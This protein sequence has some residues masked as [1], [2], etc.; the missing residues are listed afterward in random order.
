MR[1]SKLLLSAGAALV[2]ALIVFLVLSRRPVPLPAVPSSTAATSP[3]P[4]A[5]TSP[6]PPGASGT[7]PAPANAPA[8]EGESTLA[9]DLNAPG[10]TIQR[11]LAIL[12][13]VFTAWL[14]NFPRLGNPGGENRDITAAL[15]GENPV[16]F[17]FISRTHRA[18][19]AAGELCDRWG[20]PFRFHQLS[21]QHMELRSAGPDRRFGTPDDAVLTPEGAPVL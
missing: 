12:Q 18:I 3:R 15:C 4:V 6:P 2:L 5:P 9:A 19:N 11:D 13:E 7:A 10:G 20:T 8:V 1:R 16:R 21:G 14:T 17:A